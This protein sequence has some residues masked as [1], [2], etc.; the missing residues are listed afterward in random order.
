APDG[1]AAA[2][3][4]VRKTGA[5]G[6]QRDTGR[7]F[8]HGNQPLLDLGQAQAHDLVKRERLRNVEPV[9]GRAAQRREMRAAAEL[10]AEVVR[11][12]AHVGALA[13]TQPEIDPRQRKAG[14][15]EGRDT[16]ETWL[17]LDL[18]ALARLLVE[19][20]AVNLDRRI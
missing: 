7:G 5:A 6:S 2:R 12:G 18:L 19:R 1:P 13:A 16:D 10:L 20:H 3:P 14:E 4:Q 8:M 17:P 15:V 11:D 9:R